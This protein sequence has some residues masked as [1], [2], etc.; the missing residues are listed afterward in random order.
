MTDESGT[1]RPWERERSEQVVEYAMFGVRR[2][3]VRSPRNGSVHDFEI[4]TSPEGVAVVAL[5]PG[6]E[7][8]MVEQFRHGVRR[9]TLEVPS[10]VMDDGEEPVRAAL[11]ELREETGFQ[12]D[13]AELLGTLSLNPSW[14]TTRVHVVAVRGVERSAPRE[15]DR[16]EDIR[17]RLLPREEAERRVREGEIDSAVVVAALAL[18]RARGV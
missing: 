7:L 5:T 4:A 14:Q 18:A 9:A 2:D 11:R 16:G 8:V 10:G 12:G 17:V 13:G 3:R 6:G 1:P 15:Q